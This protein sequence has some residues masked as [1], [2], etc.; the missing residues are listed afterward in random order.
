MSNS[1]GDRRRHIRDSAD[2]SGNFPRIR[3]RTGVELHVLN[4]SDGGASVEGVVGLPPGAHLDVYITKNGA[5]TVVRA[6]VLRCTVNALAAGT[7]RYQ[8][9]LV[10][11][12]AG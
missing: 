6:R 11:E 9:A 5:R 12:S 3:L 7:I 2:V 8:S 10:F 1:T 4:V